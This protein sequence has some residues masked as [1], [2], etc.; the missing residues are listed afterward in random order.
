MNKIYKV[1][2]L[3]SGI[4]GIELGFIKNGFE[5][6]WANDFD[7]ASSITYQKNF[8]HPYFLKDVHTL[9]GSDLSPVD[10][11]VA[12]FPCQAFSV[13]GYRKGFNDDR[14][15]LFFE[16]IRIVNE[17][18]KKPKVLF[19]ENVKN[20]YTHDNGN[21]FKVVK[22]TLEDNDY[23]VFS[24]VLNTSEHTTIPQNRERTFIVAF[25]EGPDALEKKRNNMSKFFNSIFPPKENKKTYPIQK[26]LENI[27]V[28]N[29]YYYGPD[30]YMY[31]ELESHMK[32]KDT[33]Y[34]WRR[35]YVREN[36]SNVCPTLTANMGTGGHNVPLIIDDFG[37]RKLTPRECLSFQG[38]PRSFKI[39]MEVSTGQLYKQAGNSVT[40]KLI[41]ILAKQ[42]KQ[43]LDNRFS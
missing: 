14:G 40:V 30:K 24:K 17:L 13:A 20:F 6:S 12:G 10:V 21:T 5:I 18:K 26:Y 9:K 43:T 27:K 16:I 15:N 41:E 39:P 33:V 19:L 35:L 22:K 1:G 34:Q 23:T 2:A 8:N 11:L 38:F 42:I 4:G 25:N 37:F 32:S 29:K 28:D 3:F 36:K 31:K 7:L